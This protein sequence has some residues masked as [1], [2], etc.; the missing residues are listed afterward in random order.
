MLAA[1]DISNISTSVLSD[2]V[3]LSSTIKLILSTGSSITLFNR[4][5][6]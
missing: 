6:F 5:R 4:L 3:L 1:E 2:R